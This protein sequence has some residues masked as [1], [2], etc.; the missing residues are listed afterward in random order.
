MNRFFF[1]YV[2]RIGFQFQDG[3]SV[4]DEFWV[5]NEELVN[6]FVVYLI[7]YILHGRTNNRGDGLLTKDYFRVVNSRDL[8][9]NDCGD[10][11]AQLLHVELVPPYYY[12]GNRSS[13]I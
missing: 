9:F 11:V 8:L 10:R 1:W 5:G 4:P 7:N 2:K 13:N 6:M 3:T 12:Q